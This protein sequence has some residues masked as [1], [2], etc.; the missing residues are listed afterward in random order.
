M[1]AFFL[2]CVV[3][4][5]FVVR[6]T[7]GI[8]DGDPVASYGEMTEQTGGNR[9]RSNPASSTAVAEATAVK[10]YRRDI[11]AAWNGVGLAVESRECRWMLTAGYED[12][13]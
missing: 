12:P 4:G 1:M 11:D 2:E 5:R 8:K 9:P 3:D 13:S 10:T 6:G 7:G